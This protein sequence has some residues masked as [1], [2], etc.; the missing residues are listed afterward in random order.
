MENTNTPYSLTEQLWKGATAFLNH[1]QTQDGSIVE[2]LEIFGKLSEEE[3]HFNAISLVYIKANAEE[4]PNIKG[5]KDTLL[6]A[7]TSIIGANYKKEHLHFLEERA[8][9][10]KTG[11]GIHALDYY[12]RLGSYHES[13]R[14]QVIDFVV[15]HYTT[16]SKEQLNITGFYLYN[17]YPKTQ[18]Y[19]SLFQTIVNFHK[20]IAPEKNEN[21]MGYLEPETK[22]WWKFW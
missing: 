22:P 15:N 6:H 16:F 8:Q 2:G 7:I 17:V 9:T 5:L 4:N 21:P 20:G 14:P 12:L 11:Q 19:F 18:E 1:E 10:E 13:L 3:H